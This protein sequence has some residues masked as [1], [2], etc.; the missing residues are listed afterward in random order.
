MRRNAILPSKRETRDYASSS[1]PNERENYNFATRVNRKM[2][3]SARLLRFRDI[4][5]EPEHARILMIVSAEKQNGGFSTRFGKA[6]PLGFL[7][8]LPRFYCSPAS[9]G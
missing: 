8:S 2:E 5:K 9:A 6:F 3:K 7:F 4:P 1:N